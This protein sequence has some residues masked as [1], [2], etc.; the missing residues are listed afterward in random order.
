MKRISIILLLQF[1]AIFLLGHFALAATIDP[2]FSVIQQ[3]LG[4][5]TKDVR[6]VAAQLINVATGLLGIVTVFVILFGGFSWMISFGEEEKVQKAK[7]TI[8]SGII[9]LILILTSYSIANYIFTAILS[10]V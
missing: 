1:I 8:T 10:A 5:S 7:A 9:G 4:M 2:G 6:I 3:P